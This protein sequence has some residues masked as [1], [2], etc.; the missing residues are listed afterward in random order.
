MEQA[1]KLDRRQKEVLGLALHYARRVVTHPIFSM[2]QYLPV[3][4]P[5]LVMIHGGAGSGKSFLISSI[6]AMMT[7]AFQK[8]G[9]DPDCPYVLLTS[10]TGAASSNINGQT[11]HSTFGFKFGTTYLSMPEK[12][13]AEKR[14]LFRNLRCL[15]IDEIS[16]VSA[17]MLYNVDLRLREITGRL[18]TVFGGVS[19]FLF[20]DLYQ[21]QPPKARYV[22]DTPTNKEHAL[23]YMLRNLWRLFTV[24]NLETNHRQGEDRVYGDLLNRVRTAEHTEEDIAALRTRV[25]PR[26]DPSLDS[27]ALHIYGTNAKVNARNEAK[28]NEIDGKLFIIK[29]KNSSRTV[30]TFSTNKAGRIMNTPFMAVLKLKIGCEVVMVHNVDT[31]DGLTNGCRGVL[32]DVEM[33]GEAVSR[34]VVKLH[35]PEHGRLA[36][37][38]NPCKKFPQ[39][40]YIDAIHW[41]YLLGGATAMVYQFPITGAAAITSHKIQVSFYHIQE[42]KLICFFLKNCH[43]CTH[44]I[45]I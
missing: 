8:A 13:R 27:N 35:N 1:R 19:V 40:T 9:D 37:Q 6:Y 14:A 31:L 42:L 41:T 12:Q 17:D 32:V 5:P 38:K 39:A 43:F 22:F 25:F 20:G 2:R 3:P 45:Q 33:K 28:L 7:D 36:R 4:T 15:I 29:A 11:L 26:S 30:T 16:M 18:D 24:V 23:S 44:L 21:L 34:L 10:F